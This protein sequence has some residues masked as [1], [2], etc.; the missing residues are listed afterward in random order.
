VEMYQSSAGL[1]SD[2]AQ[3]FKDFWSLPEDFTW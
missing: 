3:E 1:S 2:F